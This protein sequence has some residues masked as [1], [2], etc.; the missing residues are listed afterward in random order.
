MSCQISPDKTV[1]LEK[2][3]E[4]SSL[5][6]SHTLNLTSSEILGKIGRNIPNRFFENFN[7]TGGDLITPYGVLPKQGSIF[8][9]RLTR[10]IDFVAIIHERYTENIRK[11]GFH[12]CGV[13]FLEKIDFR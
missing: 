10:H 2:S 1:I 12:E 5:K 7:C 6:F 8:A 3:Y 9:L 11:G 4:Y 13:F